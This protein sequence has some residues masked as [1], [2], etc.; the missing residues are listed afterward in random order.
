MSRRSI[1]ADW[2]DPPQRPPPSGGRSATRFGC[3]ALLLLVALA[4]ASCGGSSEE[5]RQLDWTFQFASTQLAKV[6]ESLVLEN[7]YIGVVA[8]GGTALDYLLPEIPPGTKARPLVWQGPA[9]PWT[10]VLKDAGGGAIRI[11]AY[12]ESREAPI[13]QAM[14]QVTHTAR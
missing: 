3:G 1:Q 14:V 13:A 8:G 6:N 12:G 4:L 2:R 11:E 5:Q 10:V 9:A 7:A